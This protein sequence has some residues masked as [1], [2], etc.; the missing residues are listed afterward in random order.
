M[1]ENGLPMAF[2]KAM[3]CFDFRSSEKAANEEAYRSKDYLGD[4]GL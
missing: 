3:T 1:L 4:D 2:L